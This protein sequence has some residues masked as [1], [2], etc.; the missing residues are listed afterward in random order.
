MDNAAV[1]VKRGGGGHLP[2]GS[3]EFV[4]ATIRDTRQ[5]PKLDYYFSFADYSG[6]GIKNV[7]FR[8]P[9]QLVGARHKQALG[10]FQGE[11]VK[12]IQR[13]DDPAVQTLWLS[14]E[15]RDSAKRQHAQ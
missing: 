6:I 10:L 7:V 1:A 2:I 15:K 8:N 14:A 13:P 3:V 5:L 12:E 4:G 9:V 11:G